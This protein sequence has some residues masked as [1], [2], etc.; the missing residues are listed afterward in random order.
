MAAKCCI[1]RS[2]VFR[3]QPI[4]SMRSFTAS[5]KLAAY[6]RYRE[7]DSLAARQRNMVSSQAREQDV[8]ASPK[9]RPAGGSVTDRVSTPL[10]FNNCTDATTAQKPPPAYPVVAQCGANGYNL[11]L[12]HAEASQR[13]VRIATTY[14]SDKKHSAVHNSPSSIPS[15]MTKKALQYKVVVVLDEEDNQ[16]GVFPDGSLVAF[17]VE[18]SELEELRKTLRFCSVPRDPMVAQQK[19]VHSIIFRYLTRD[20]VPQLGFELPT[21]AEGEGDEEG[22][23]LLPSFVD[24]GKLSAIIIE[25]DQPQHKLPFMFCLAEM[26][27]LK[28]LEGLVTPVAGNVSNWQEHVKRTGKLPMTM[29][30]ARKLRARLLRLTSHLSKISAARHRIFWESESTLLRQ[31]FRA[32][33]DHLEL[34]VLHDQ[35]RERLDVVGQSLGYL[36]EEAHAET[37]HHLEIV[38]I[39]LIVVEVLVA[40]LGVHH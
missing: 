6:H 7:S 3:M 34:S 28:A 39:V 15:R 36:C 30:E 33:F 2:D 35:L 10:H 17:G 37:N 32:T 24:D 25:S 26:V 13:N 29:T 12:L 21:R 11:E 16:I 1:Q 9:G 5:A 8:E 20:M 40:L 27:Q 14:P 4:T 22:E 18:D 19:E 23:L 38:I 31:T